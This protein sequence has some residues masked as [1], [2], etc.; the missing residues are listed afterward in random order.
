LCGFLRELCRRFGLY[1][2]GFCRARC[3]RCSGFH[4]GYTFGFGFL[5][6]NL[7]NRCRRS[8]CRCFGF[9]TAIG[10]HY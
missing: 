7:G 4:T 5:V 1:L 6:V 3:D 8:R 9:A 2:G 10:S